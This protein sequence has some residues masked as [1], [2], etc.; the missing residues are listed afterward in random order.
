MKV[1]YTIRTGLKPVELLV[2]GRQ[3]CR[4]FFYTLMY[5]RYDVIDELDVKIA[6]LRAKQTAA[7]KVL[8]SARIDKQVIDAE[9]DA[10][11]ILVAEVRHERE[12]ALFFPMKK[13]EIAD[14]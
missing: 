4:P 5:W 14:A 11:L 8:E 2:V 6:A 3:Q 9:V 1:C 13:S 10:L 7:D 12:Q